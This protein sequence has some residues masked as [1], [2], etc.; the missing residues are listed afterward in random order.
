MLE[1]VIE[2][3]QV[4]ANAALFR[5]SLWQDAKRIGMGG[6]HATAQASEREALKICSGRLGR[7]PDRVTKL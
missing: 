2:C 7:H 3:W 6:P 5:W 1:L 4:P